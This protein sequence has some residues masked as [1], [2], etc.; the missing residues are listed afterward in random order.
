MGNYQHEEEL[1]LFNKEIKIDSL[2]DEDL[3]MILKSFP[4]AAHP[5]GV[6]SSLTSA[7]IAFNPSSVDIDSESDMRE[8]IIMLLAKFPILAS[9]TSKKS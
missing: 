6:L 5:M 9:W 4:K 1:D 2:V 3:K 7:L 8:A